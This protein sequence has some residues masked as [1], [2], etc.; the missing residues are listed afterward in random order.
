MVTP[1]RPIE[2]A[3]TPDPGDGIFKGPATFKLAPRVAP[4]IIDLE[5]I[6][7][8]PEGSDADRIGKGLRTAPRDAMIAA[9]SPPDQLGRA[10]GVHRTLD[11]V[12]AVIGPLVAFLLLWWIP[13]G[14]LTVMVISLGFAVLGVA[15]LG[16][17]VPDRR[18]TGPRPIS[19]PMRWPVSNELIAVTPEA[20]SARSNDSVG[21]IRISSSNARA[22]TS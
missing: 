22:S 2:I 3:P 19:E 17:L 5:D 14:Y 10:F 7:V 8:A 1:P 21:A 16:L 11:T 12:G 4:L 6:P 18:S 9:A 20:G 13:D 15:M